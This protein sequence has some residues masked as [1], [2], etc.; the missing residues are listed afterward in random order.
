VPS[1]VSSRVYAILA[2]ALL[3]GCNATAPSPS[4][5]PPTGGTLRVAIVEN[6][7]EALPGSPYYDPANFYAFSPLTRCCLLRTLLSF[8]GRPTEEGGAELRPDLAEELPSV[9]A[10]GLTW[11]FKLRAGLHYA[12]PLADRTIE[13]RDFITSLEHAIRAGEVPFFDD[14][15]GVPEFRDGSVD[16]I[17]GI[18]AP[19]ERTLRILLAAPAGDLGNRVALPILA[20]LPAEAL[21]GREDA[22]YAGFLVA[23]GPYMYEGADGLNL[24]DADAPPIWADR[25]TGRLS[26]VRNPSWSRAIDPLRPAHADRIEVVMVSDPDQGIDLIESDEADVLGEPVPVSVA[27]RYLA[28]DALRARLFSQPAMRVQYMTMNL[29]VPPFDDVHV[30]RAVNLVID[31]A[32]AARAVGEAR[33]SSA[34]VAHHALPDG[35]ENALLRTYDPYPSSGD[36]G[37]LEGARDEMRQSAYDANDD[38][39]CDAAFCSNVQAGTIGETADGSPWA[40]IV[41]DL[42][43]IGIELVPAEAD[44]F[45]AQS[46]VAALIGI[47]WGVD[48]PNGANFTGLLS[49]EGISGDGLVN[50]SLIGASTEQLASFGYEVT[51]VPS[52]EGKLASCRQAVGSA[53]F[54]CW[55]EVDQLIMERVVPW[56]PLAFIDHNWVFS[57]RV[58]EFSPDADSVAPALDQIRLRPED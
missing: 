41:S 49:R 10:D 9:S 11:T 33:E 21:A 23:S 4:S 35:V 2:C 52:L 57:E 22:D 3:L 50:I 20:P 26:L 8:N 44:P 14:I 7:G 24:A 29:A 45:L 16:T 25:P 32:A 27:Q 46:H 36:G 30:R 28:S 18:E 31:R 39:R 37:D 19:D 42:A 15:V 47:G 53:A 12:P 34:V 58:V 43:K 40:L 6:G 17:A 1:P 5:Q 13:A 51:E 38:G 54:M 56:V 55:A 48:Y